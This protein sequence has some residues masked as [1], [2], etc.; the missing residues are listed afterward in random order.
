MMPLRQ[1]IEFFILEAL[2]TSSV[3]IGAGSIKA[4]LGKKGIVRSEAGIGRNLRELQEKGFVRKEGYQGHV[5]TRK[6]EEYL[7]SLLESRARSQVARAL[8]SRIT[9]DEASLMDEILHARRAIETEA[10]ALAAERATEEQLDGLRRNIKKQKRLLEAG[11]SNAELD[12]QFHSMI[13]E[14]SGNRLLSS[15]YRL[16]GMNADLAKFFEE[17]RIRHGS[18]LGVD[19]FEVFEAIAARNS[20]EAADNMARHIDH[21]IEDAKEYFN[22][23]WR[24]AE[25]KEPLPS[26]GKR[27]SG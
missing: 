24:N 15:M 14:A 4:F 6:G 17:V 8:V 21:T 22:S 3:A 5:L 1:D 26:A 10:A 19:H 18:R 25:G 9:S 23:G 16:I 12:R 7:A 27:I 2:S 13:L 20:K 11:M